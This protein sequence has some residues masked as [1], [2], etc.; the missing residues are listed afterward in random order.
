MMTEEQG[1]KHKERLVQRVKDRYFRKVIAHPEGAVVHFGD[2]W[3]Y[4]CQICN[5]GLHADLIWI[6]DHTAEELYPKFWDEM[7]V[8]HMRRDQLQELPIP[9]PREPTPEEK[10]EMDKVFE[11][12]FGKKLFDENDPKD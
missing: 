7:A 2:C 4:C 8:S 1:A 6:N 5:C 11:E 12:V 10:A 3:W 9:V